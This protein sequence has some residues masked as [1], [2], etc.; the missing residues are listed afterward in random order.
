MK[1]LFAKAEGTQVC[2]IPST[3]LMKF[4]FHQ[5]LQVGARHFQTTFHSFHHETLDTFS[6]D[7]LKVFQGV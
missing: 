7:L 2:G 5:L 4:L 3:F 1:I 6:I